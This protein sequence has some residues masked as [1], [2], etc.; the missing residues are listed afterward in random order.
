MKKS[1]LHTRSFNKSKLP[2]LKHWIY[3]AISYRLTQPS[4]IKLRQIY[5]YDFADT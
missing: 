5:A 4:H 3:I 2:T 1:A